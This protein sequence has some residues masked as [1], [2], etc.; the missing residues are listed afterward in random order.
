M[1]IRIDAL[2]AGIANRAHVLPAMKDGATVKLAI[3]ALLGLIE[4]GDLPPDVES[5]LVLAESALQ[6]I[7]NLGVTTAKIAD[8]N[9]TTAK[10]A[11]DGVTNPK[12]ANMAQATVKGRASGAGTGDP[13]DLA[14]ADLFTI[15]NGVFPARP[16]AAAGAGQVVTWATSAG[17]GYSA[18]SSGTWVVI[19]A[20]YLQS[21]AA[22]A[23]GIS[24]A[25]VAGGSLVQ[26]G[27]SGIIFTGVA[28][29]IA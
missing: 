22:W 6:S 13:A 1:P 5:A 20:G 7:P 17:N 21:T 2:A 12:L 25:V 24:I 16:Q 18:P 9:V 23:A 29:R 28:W 8:S 3:S 19:W 27:S 11:D 4:R 15:L 26:P 14:A 10:L